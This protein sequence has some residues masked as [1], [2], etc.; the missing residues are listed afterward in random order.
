MNLKF[1]IIIHSALIVE[2]LVLG[3][4]AVL[5]F[6]KKTPVSLP[7]GFFF[8]FAIFASISY[9]LALS[10]P[11]IFRSQIRYFLYYSNITMLVHAIFAFVINFT[12]T[13]NKFLSIPVRFCL[14]ITDIICLLIVTL[15]GKINVLETAEFLGMKIFYAT[16]WHWYFNVHLGLSYYYSLGIISLLIYKACSS[17]KHNRRRYLNILVIFSLVIL[18]NGVVIITKS[19]F[20][21]SIFSYGFGAL[22]IYISCFKYTSPSYMLENMQNVIN[23][24]SKMI[25]CFDENH[26]CIWYNEKFKDYFRDV[27]DMQNFIEKNFEAWRNDSCQFD[28]VT[29]TFEFITKFEKDNHPRSIH[30]KLK[31]NYDNLNNYMGCFF[32]CEDVTEKLNH[33]KEQKLLANMDSLTGL[34]KRDFFFSSVKQTI[35]TNPDKKFLLICSNIVDFKI[36]NSIFGEDA[37]NNL[38]RQN[39]TYISEYNDKTSCSGRISGDMFALLIEEN[40][41]FE[42]P[43]MNA[44]KIMENEFS[45]AFYHLHMQMGIYRIENLNESVT[46]M[47]E[48]A[49]LAMK[50]SK[51]NLNEHICWYNSDT[52]NQ[53]LDEKIILGKFEKSLSLGEFKMFLQPQVTKENKVLGAE[54]LV[55]WIDSDGNI[56]TPNK[57]IPVL[58]KTGLITKLDTYIWEEAAKQLE[59][60]KNLGREDLHISV[61]ISIKDFYYEDLYKVFTDLV[62]KYNIN[63]NNFNLE[64]TESVFATDAQGVNNLLQK[65]RDFGFHIEL[66]DFGSGYSSL[67]LLKEISVDTLKIDMSFLRHSIESDELKT[68]KSWLILNEISRLAKVLKMNTIVEGVEEKEQVDKLSEFGCD[69]FQGYFFARP[70]SIHAFEERIRLY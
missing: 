36:Y 12:G 4:L 45:N 1:F 8:T 43:F 47:V 54:A 52:L 67:G 31:K 68:E 30:I 15:S 61:N 27:F 40:H 24:S 17:P 46:S 21:Y 65:L 5:C 7:M 10:A 25:S 38:L 32:V 39:A 37:G 57:F 55:R 59:K 19:P 23:F 69:V 70:E 49:I 64:I 50:L 6:R 60:W 35:R 41:Y 14:S 9:S 28:E 58:E 26:K 29:D 63:P 62:E 22:L 53:N 34:S 11:T 2:S 44:M 33:E 51:N 66:D 20:D 56:I 13:K 18:V 42:D 3:V 16:E 48:K